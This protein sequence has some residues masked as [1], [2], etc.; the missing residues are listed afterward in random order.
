MKQVEQTRTIRNNHKLLNEI[1][2]ITTKGDTKTKLLKTLY[3]N[4]DKRCLKGNKWY[5]Q[6]LKS[7]KKL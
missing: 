5:S 6:C 1:N 2:Q 7:K 4:I 3:N